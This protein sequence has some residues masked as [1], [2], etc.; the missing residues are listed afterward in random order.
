MK[1]DDI[2]AHEWAVAICTFLAQ[3]VVVWIIWSGMSFLP[4][5]TYWEVFGL[6]VI[7]RMLL[8]KAGMQ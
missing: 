4:P 1:T 6:F 3:T 2:K 7:V 8:Y 5:A